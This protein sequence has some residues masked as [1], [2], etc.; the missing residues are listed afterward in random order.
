MKSDNR[1]VD[2]LVGVG[3]FAIVLSSFLT[4]AAALKFLFTDLNQPIRVELS[5]I[6]LTQNRCWLFCSPGGQ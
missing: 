3:Y 4:G 1:F 5:D 2:S 6:Q